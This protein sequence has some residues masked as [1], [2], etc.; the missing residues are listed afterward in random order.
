VTAENQQ[1]INF[2]QINNGKTF[3]PVEVSPG[4]NI[5]DIDANARYVYVTVR[6]AHR[7]YVFKNDLD[8]Y[9]IDFVITDTFMPYDH[10]TFYPRETILSPT[11][12]NVLVIRNINSI[13]IMRI[14][15]F[16]HEF[17]SEIFIDELSDY[18]A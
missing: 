11:D 1:V 3:N 10:T 7:I 12:I 17:I 2:I 15:A 6:D 8:K 5:T 18:L 9:N 4:Y 14:T 16:T 13:I